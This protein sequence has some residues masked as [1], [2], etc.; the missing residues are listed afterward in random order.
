MIHTSDPSSSSAPDLLDQHPARWP[1]R[2][3]S[4]RRRW[5]LWSVLVVLVV[6]MLVTMVWLAG[7]Y[8]ASQV[9]DK[10]ERDTA[11]AV[12]DV[13]AALSRNLQDLLALHIHSEDAS[14]WRNHANELL[15]QRR[16]LGCAWNGA[17]WTCGSK[18]MR[19]PPIAPCPGR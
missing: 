7:R 9:Q 6:S 15:Q 1:W 8:E 5:S 4:F 10:L 3:C 11:N 17:A 19:K 12:G 2:S 13:R 18:A 14:L 16:E